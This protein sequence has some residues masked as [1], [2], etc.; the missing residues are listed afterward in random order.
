MNDERPIEKLLRRYAKKRRDEAG[1]PLSLH[2]AT[3]RLLQGEVARQYPKASRE[4]R[5]STT[6]FLALWAQKW[7]FALGVLV[8]LAVTAVVLVPTFKS[9]PEAEFLAQKKTSEDIAVRESVAPVSAPAPAETQLSIVTLADRPQNQPAPEPAGGGNLSPRRDDSANRSYAL[10]NG[11]AAGSLSRFA[12]AKSDADSYRDAQES[13]Q[14]L[15]GVNLDSAAP[16]TRSLSVPSRSRPA[17]ETKLADSLATSGNAPLDRNDA[18]VAADRFNESRQP[19]TPS[20]LA[21]AAPSVSSRVQDKS[22]VARGG[23]VEKDA[24]RFYSQ[25]FA[26]VAPEELRAKA[27]KVKSESPVIPVLSKFQVQ[28]VGDQLRVIDG[29]G[30]TYLGEVNK[31]IAAAGAGT[32]DKETTT[33][34][35]ETAKRP[36]PG[37]AGGVTANQQAT[38]NYFWR[39]EGTNR[40]LNQNVVFTWN[41]VSTTNISATTQLNAASGVLNQNAATL[42]SQFP[43]LLNNSIINGR[44]Q[45]GR[46]QQIEVNAVPVKP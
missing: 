13:K 32:D 1:D 16:A 9:S 44:A 10:T 6:G 31:N 39:V 23:E 18:V 11:V 43:A 35:F 20:P 30:S 2:P 26:N 12:D 5:S 41:F 45:L 38:Q 8:V 28:Q 17:G 14:V 46:A 21:A 36:A 3:R 33:L 19:A 15:L 34:A 22:F 42:P 25:S 24:E 29:D 27:A 37:F 40:T 4:G 7:A